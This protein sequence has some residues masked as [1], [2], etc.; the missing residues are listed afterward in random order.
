MSQERVTE[1]QTGL[2]CQWFRQEDYIPN[3]ASH[4]V[5]VWKLSFTLFLLF[6]H[7]DLAPVSFSDLFTTGCM[8]LLKDLFHQKTMHSAHLLG[9]VLGWQVANFQNWLPY[10][11]VVF[12]S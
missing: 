9:D 4:I 7:L 8:V 12:H 1:D 11:T 6:P 3:T 5:P 10:S 2:E